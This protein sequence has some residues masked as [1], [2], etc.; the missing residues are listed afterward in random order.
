MGWWLLGLGEEQT[1]SSCLVGTE[2]QPAKLKICLEV[3][4]G[5]SH[6]SGSIL[7][8]TV[9]LKLITTVNLKLYIIADFFK[10]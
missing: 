7:N 5:S 8:V 4:G 6:N 9:H 10:S 3:S 2:F 1:R